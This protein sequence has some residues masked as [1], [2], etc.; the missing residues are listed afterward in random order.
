MS[1]I[2][3]G[4]IAEKHRLIRRLDQESNNQEIKEKIKVLDRLDKQEVQKWLKLNKEQKQK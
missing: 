2:I 4:W 3:N 1:K